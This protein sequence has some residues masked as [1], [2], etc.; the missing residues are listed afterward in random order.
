MSARLALDVL[1]ALPADA[2][3]AHLGGVY[4]HSPWVAEQ[5]ALQ[6]PFANVT[7]L[8]AA[9]AA[10]VAAASNDIKLALLRVHP[11]LAGRA[12]VAGALTAASRLEQ[13]S[14]GLD[15]LS[16]DEMVRFQVANAAYRDR[17]GFPFILAVKHWHKQQILAAFDGRLGNGRAAELTIALA[18]VDK[19]AFSRLLDLVEPVASGRLTT[20]VLDTALGR[21]AA[22]MAVELCRLAEDGGGT[23]LKRLHTNAD[24]R[25]D[26]PALTGAELA[27]GRYCL[28]FA[29]GEYFLASGQ[30]LSAPSFLD[31]VPIRF[32]I[33][34]P[35]HH[36]HVPLLVSPWSYSTYRGS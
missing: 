4:E 32:A 2:F 30:T 19:I 11:D 13:A 24:G 36:Y 21:P 3:T 10:V 9:M 17:F 28:S 1:N 6:R 27:V 35:E 16:A 15:R 22:A 29:V 5:V 20:H 34:N 18:E 25:L 14:A 23:V 12:A 31:V 8:H 7:A 33:A 26:A